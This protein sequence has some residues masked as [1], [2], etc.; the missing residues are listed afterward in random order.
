MTST[1]FVRSNRLS[2]LRV[3]A[4]LLCSAAI[5]G[6]AGTAQAACAPLSPTD[7]DSVLCTG[8]DST[9]FEVGPTIDNVTV[10]VEAGALL[11]ERDP[12]RTAAIGVNDDSTVIL[13]SV[14]AGL[15]EPAT[16]TVTE[17][18]GFGIRAGDNA[19][20]DI[21]STIVV[22]GAGARGISVGGRATTGAT[23]PTILIRGGHGVIPGSEP[24]LSPGDLTRVHG[25]LV[26]FRE[27]LVGG[28]NRLLLQ[29]V[30]RSDFVQF[31]TDGPRHLAIL[32]SSGVDVIDLQN[33][34]LQG[35]VDLGDGADVILYGTGSFIEDTV[36]GAIDGGA[37]NDTL[38]FGDASASFGQPQQFSLDALTSI[39]VVTVGGGTGWRFLR[40]ETFDGEL[41][42]ADGG[43]LVVPIIDDVRLGGDFVAS[44]T[45]TLATEFNLSAPTLVIDGNAFFAG[46]LEL[47]GLPDLAIQAAP[48][49]LIS[50]G[51]SVSGTFSDF[52]LPAPS[53]FRTIEPSYSSAGLG[54]L[55]T[56]RADAELVRDSSELALFQNLQGM[57]GAA[58][59]SPELAAV[60]TALN[61]RS[62]D[63]SAASFFDTLNPESYDA[64]TTVLVE[65]GRQIAQLL[66]SRPR[67]CVIGQLDP[68]TARTAPIPC[69]ERRWA[70]W[71]TTLGSARQ[72]DAFTG[73]RE[74]DAQLGGLLA[75][76]DVRPTDPLTLTLSIGSQRGTIDVEN[77]GKTTL[78]TIDLAAQAAY[79][80]GP[81]R[82]QALV[83][84]GHGFHA[85]RRSI[86]IATTA[87]AP[88]NVRATDDHESDRVTLAA[89]AGIEIPGGPFLFEP[90][91]G[92]DWS[93]VSQ[94]EIS[95]DGAGGLGLQIDERDDEVGSVS[96]GVRI[97]SIYRHNRFLAR[98]LDW[99][100]GVWRPQVDLRYRQLVEGNER[101]IDARFSGAAPSLP[102]FR[103]ETKE[104]QGGWELGAGIG[105]VPE[106]ANRLQFDLRYDAFLA[107]HTLEH[108][109]MFRMQLGF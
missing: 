34:L 94:E 62:L 2:L 101:Q 37:G 86:R 50:V 42:I 55:V 90:L 83:G 38:A 36:V 45:G 49:P 95:E 18:N 29:G 14:A 8:T 43:R 88:T 76:V 71:L 91:I 53:G 84:W 92:F 40:S 108:D 75:G 79:T 73:N 17:A 20:I 107:S 24:G 19:T 52:A 102:G 10:T 64:Q 85:D 66:F 47:A 68:W 96:G 60:A 22:E 33:G 77:S 51:G 28:E 41:R 61:D 15:P 25:P 39:E 78:T 93:W 56:G 1:A 63:G 98:Q 23:D 103:V 9:G 89:E 48:Y 11:D 3:L 80:Q 65:S 99:M 57:V 81:F 74:Y 21:G 31:D 16:I 27:A 69:N 59:V 105:F 109:L 46:T 12:G 44:P 32:G 54:I 106:D 4:G 6:T 5:L 100:D 70:P 82:V 67:D 58:G 13:E 87:T 26:E 30:L 97:S 104:D 72:R 35:S 7:G